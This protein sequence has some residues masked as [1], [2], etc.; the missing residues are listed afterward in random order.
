LRALD[1]EFGMPNYLGMNN[2]A[3]SIKP[4]IKAI[5]ILAAL[6]LTVIYLL[7]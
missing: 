3:L 6:A 4:N 2:D 5:A 7:Q 1:Y